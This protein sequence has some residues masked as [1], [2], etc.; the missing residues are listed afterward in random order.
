MGS[1]ATR[2][3]KGH[4]PVEVS[5]GRPLASSMARPPSIRRQG[6]CSPTEMPKIRSSSSRCH[7]T[8]LKRRSRTGTWVT[9]STGTIRDGGGG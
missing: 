7:S 5:T 2:G 6:S 3:S 1:S 4:L 9:S 8:G